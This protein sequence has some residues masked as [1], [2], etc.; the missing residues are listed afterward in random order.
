MKNPVEFYENPFMV[1]TKI[2]TT[3]HTIPSMSGVSI[4]Y[5]VSISGYIP[6][7]IVG[8]VVNDYTVTIRGVR[9]SGSTEAQIVIGNPTSASI[10]I[11]D[12]RI[13]ILYQ[14]V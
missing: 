3:L 14:K 6:I 8:Y 1:S 13:Y 2:D 7:G 11:T 10:N 12:I 9:M 5:D 4:F